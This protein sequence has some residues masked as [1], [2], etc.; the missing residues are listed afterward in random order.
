MINQCC[1][2][3]PPLTNRMIFRFWSPLAMTWLMMAVEG[4]FVAALIARLDE[5]KFNL[6]AFSV[7][8][9]LAMI[10]ESPIIMMMTAANAL[11]RDR[12]SF[13][14]LRR[15][16]Y[17]MNMLV[18]L[19]MLACIAPP[20]LDFLTK[21]VLNLP[22][23]VS[24]LVRDAIVFL[25]PWPAS[26]GYRRFNQGLL[27]ARGDTRLVAYGTIVRLS[28]MG[29]AGSALYLFSSL[30]G[31]SVG[32]ISLTFGVFAEAI[33]SRIMAGDEIE[34]LK[35]KVSDPGGRKLTMSFI[36]KFYLPLATTSMLAI[37]IQ[38]LVTFFMGQS[39]KAIE[40]L[41]VMPV[42]S[43]LVFIFRSFGVAYQEVVV[44]LLGRSKSNYAA[45]RNFALWLGAISTFALCTVAFTPVSTFWL[46]VVSGLSRELSLFSVK[47]LAV[48]SLLPAVSLLLIWLQSLLVTSAKTQ[49][50]SIGTVIEVSIIALT[51]YTAIR[52]FEA[53]GVM[54]A[55][56]GL[57][58]G[59]LCACSFLYMFKGSFQPQDEKK[60]LPNPASF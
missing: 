49:P 9:A 31:V 54:A 47:P 41:A 6:A 12:D 27:I 4:P 48:M 44:A 11:V 36:L 33:A 21:T 3:N 10:F 40:S 56:F 17:F 35:I 14:T 52:H 19:I 34:K 5:P 59:R 28:S 32:A 57:V 38:P 22:D 45:L 43:S 46:G 30:P 15:F 60:E 42:I 24:V 50:I 58:T 55:A 16:N 26:I 18:T 1:F 2:E 20:V 23:N 25:L 51:M 8:F 37:A 7:S 53:T 29:L 13:L 39:L